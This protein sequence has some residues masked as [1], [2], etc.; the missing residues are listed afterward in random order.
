MMKKLAG[1]LLMSVVVMSGSVWAS[2]GGY[3]GYGNESK[4]TAFR[5]ESKIALNGYCAVCLVDAGQKVPGSER[6]AFEF[7]GQKYLFPSVDQLNSF[8]ENPKKYIKD[9][10]KIL[11]KMIK[12]EAH[13]HGSHGHE[14]S[15][16]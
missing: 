3:A 10:P 5:T 1:V 9:A 11:A 4:P 13:D 7:K 16:H 8:K 12:N 14:G 2:G 6:F 15:H